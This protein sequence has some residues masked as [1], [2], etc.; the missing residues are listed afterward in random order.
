MVPEFPALATRVIDEMLAADPDLARSAGDHRVDGELP[1]WRPDAVAARLSVA[2][3]AADALSSLDVDALTVAE[4]VDHAQLTNLVDRTIYELTEVRTHEWDPLVHNPGILLHAL[5]ARPYA[6]VEE[7]L[8]SVA[9]RLAAIPDALATARGLLV[10]C[11][12]VHLETAVGQFEGT[13]T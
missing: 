9:A 11:P 4:Q 6:P 5:I 1:D 10:D 8:A 3:D 13:A 7:R 2:R 12:R